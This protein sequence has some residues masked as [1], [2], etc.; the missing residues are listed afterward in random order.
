[1]AWLSVL[2]LAPLLIITGGAY[3]NL[4][5]KTIIIYDTPKEKLI[6]IAK[7][8][9]LRYRMVIEQDQESGENLQFQ[10]RDMD[11]I[12]KLSEGT[13]NVDKWTIEIIN[14]RKLYDLELI[15][16]DMKN[17]VYE[18]DRQ[19][20]RFRGMFDFLFGMAIFCGIVWFNLKFSNIF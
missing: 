6:Q 12:V 4:R 14:Y 8:V 1:M 5:K 10:V 2:Y 13:M 11:V 20:K 3:F 7:D 16:E 9:F 18:E 19:R 17:A 15:V